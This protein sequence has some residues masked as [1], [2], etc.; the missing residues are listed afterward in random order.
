MSVVAGTYGTGLR[1]RK[2]S[3]VRDHQSPVDL[4]V[5]SLQEEDSFVH[6]TTSTHNVA[7]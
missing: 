1:L 4:Y 3:D 6:T 5:A 7:H 2:C